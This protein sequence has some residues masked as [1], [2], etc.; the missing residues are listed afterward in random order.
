MKIDKTDKTDRVTPLATTEVPAKPAPKAKRP[1]VERVETIHLSSKLTVAVLYEDRHLLAI[2]K[3]SGYL[4]APVSWEHTSRNIMLMLREG[5]ERMT[6]WAKRRSLR[7]INNVHRIDADT[8]GVLLLAKNRVALTHMTARFEQRQ[9]EKTYITLVEGSPKDD[10][11][12]VDLPL[13]PHATRVGFIIVDRREGRDALTKFKVLERL[14]KYTLL[15][16]QP[17]TGRTHQ[18]RVHL[19]AVGLPVVSDPIYNQMDETE[20]P[21]L[22]RLALHATGLGFLHPL[23]HKNVSISCPL[24]KDF[25]NA[26]SMLR[27]IAPKTS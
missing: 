14:G 6:P 18:I 5:V 27:R 9:V 3:P 19:R 25:N 10:E 20:K 21:P 22:A 4:V 26:L 2:D 11:F 12:S 8:S 1:P 23:L 15:L 7:Y 24:P 17:L 13:I 16:A